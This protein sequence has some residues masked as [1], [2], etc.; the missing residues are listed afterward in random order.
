MQKIEQIKNSEV[1][2]TA[3]KKYGI[4]D[5]EGIK[6]IEFK[7]QLSHHDFHGETSGLLLYEI[8]TEKGKEEIF[9][10]FS[11]KNKS[12][13]FNNKKIFLEKLEEY[14]MPEN[15]PQGSLGITRILGFYPNLNLFLRENAPGVTL[16]KMLEEEHHDCSRAIQSSAKWIAK[17]HSFTPENNI[18]NTRD[19]IV[20]KNYKQY[21]KSIARIVPEKS[22]TIKNILSSISKSNKKPPEQKMMHGDF[23]AQNIIYDNEHKKTIVIDY[24]WSGIGDSLYDIGSFLIEMDYKLGKNLGE[25]KVTNLKNL[26]LKSYKKFNPLPHDSAKRINMAQAEVAIARI[27]WIIGFISDP[28]NAQLDQQTQK[29]TILNLIKKIEECMEDTN[30]INLTLYKYSTL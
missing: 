25:I 4:K 14:G 24:D 22:N 21:L 15:L 8:T 12:L 20:N 1:L 7:K 19:K 2:L 18:F 11:S 3:I 28:S 10:F 29:T 9:G 30:N 6:K 26:F 23:Q 5:R 16:L 27:N 13:R 17:M